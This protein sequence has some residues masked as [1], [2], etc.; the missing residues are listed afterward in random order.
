MFRS[1]SSRP[2]RYLSGRP[3]GPACP[4]LSDGCDRIPEKR[5]LMGWS[6][7]SDLDRFA[8]AAGKDRAF[9]ERRHGVPPV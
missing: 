7:T 3:G 5:V 8:A 9:S 6:A 2:Y 4:D 1:Q